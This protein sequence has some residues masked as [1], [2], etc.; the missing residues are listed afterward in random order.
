[1]EFYIM[2]GINNGWWNTVSFYRK[3]AHFNN[4]ESV[5]NYFVFCNISIQHTLNM[6]RLYLIQ[7]INK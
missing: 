5:S 4:C 2:A 3:N 6:R 1:M 7:K